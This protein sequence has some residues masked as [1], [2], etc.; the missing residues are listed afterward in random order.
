MSDEILIEYCRRSEKSFVVYE[1]SDLKTLW[2]DTKDG[3]V[4]NSLG[5]TGACLFWC[6]HQIRKPPY[7]EAMGYFDNEW[8]I[9][10]DVC[11]SLERICDGINET[12]YALLS[13]MIFPSFR[14]FAMTLEGLVYEAWFRWEH[15]LEFCRLQD[16]PCDFLNV[17]RFWAILTALKEGIENLPYVCVTVAGRQTEDGTFRVVTTRMSGAIISDRTV[18]RTM[19]VLDFKQGIDHQLMLPMRV[20]SDFNIYTKAAFLSYYGEWFAASKWRSACALPIANDIRFLTVDG[21]ELGSDL[22]AG[23]LADFL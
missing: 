1:G 8:S 11:S 17:R 6:I 19:S 16:F 21:M 10:D 2:C 7:L 5:C 14:T 9:S 20:A 4:V 13:N 15:A 23:F 18:S 3:A 22:D 12:G